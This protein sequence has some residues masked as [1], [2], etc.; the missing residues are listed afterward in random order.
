MRYQAFLQNEKNNYFVQRREQT[1]EDDGKNF[2]S[3]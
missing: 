1:N 3:I 2:K